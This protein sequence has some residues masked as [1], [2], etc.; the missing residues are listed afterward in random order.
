LKGSGTLLKGIPRYFSWSLETPF[1]TFLN[2]SKSSQRIIKIY[3]TFGNIFSD[4]NP[5]DKKYEIKENISNEFGEK[6]SKLG[7]KVSDFSKAPFNI[8]A[9]KS[10]EIILTKVGDN[11]NERLVELAELLDVDDL[12]I[13]TK[14]KPKDVPALKKDEFLEIEKARELIKIIK[15][16]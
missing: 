5:F 12:V 9:K 4:L 11:F 3:E 10:D 2:L 6:Y 16:F 13:F 14:K 15:E 7:F 1:G 8:A